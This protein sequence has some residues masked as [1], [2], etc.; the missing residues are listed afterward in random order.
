MWPDSRQRVARWRPGWSGRRSS[1]DAAGYITLPGSRT[2]SFP[3]ASYASRRS[4]SSLLTVENKLT[5]TA[6]SLQLSRRLVL[7]MTPYTPPGSSGGPHRHTG[8]PGRNDARDPRRDA[9]VS[10]PSR[11]LQWP[12]GVVAPTDRPVHDETREQVEDSSQVESPAFP[13]DVF[14]RALC[15]VLMK[16]VGSELLIHYIRSDVRARLWR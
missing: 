11:A 4:P 14:R 9:G 16:G 2:T 7:Q 8:C 1:D 3:A 10:A 15:P 6:L 13:D 5:M 12:D